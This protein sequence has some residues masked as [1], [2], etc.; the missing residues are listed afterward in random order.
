[1]VVGTALQAWEDRKVDA[2]LVVVHSALSL[3]LGQPRRRFGTAAEEDHAGT[4]STQ[5]L[6]RRGRDD[7]RSAKGA[8]QHLGCHE[9]A[10]VRHV[11]HHER[12][13]LVADGAHAHIVP[14]A[15]VSRRAC[16]DHLGAVHKCHLLQLV[17]VD[18]A[19]LWIQLVRERFKEDGCCRDLLVRGVVTMRQMAAA[20]QVQAHH[21]VVRL[22]QCRV[23]GEIGGA[24]RVRLHVHAPLV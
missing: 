17:V 20:R 19:G 6:V 14:V 3:A 5:R 23:D 24:A 8:V 12:A 2:V 21:A 9:A 4:R 16:N 10:H 7:V 13:D 15:R 22:Q 1:M 11:D 18:Q